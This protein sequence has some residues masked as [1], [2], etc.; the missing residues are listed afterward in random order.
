MRGTSIAGGVGAR[1]IGVR[2][3]GGRRGGIGGLVWGRGRGGREGEGVGVD[4]RGW[5]EKMES[6]GEI[7]GGEKG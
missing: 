6:G 7:G 2:G 3:R 5:G 4:E 1:G